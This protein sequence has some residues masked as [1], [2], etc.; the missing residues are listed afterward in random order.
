[1]WNYVST[2]SSLEGDPAQAPGTAGA[3][4]TAQGACGPARPWTPTPPGDCSALQNSE[5]P[6]PPAVLAP[7][8]QLRLQV[9]THEGAQTSRGYRLGRRLGRCRAVCTASERRLEEEEEG[10]EIQ[11]GFLQAEA[12]RLNLEEEG[13]GKERV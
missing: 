10:G 12:P 3:P 1:M 8:P 11:E 2:V 9:P 6:L 7:S 13:L 5:P 4:W